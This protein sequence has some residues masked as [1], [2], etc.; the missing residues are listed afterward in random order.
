M[1][2]NW[3]ARWRDV[4]RFLQPS[5]E[6]QSVDTRTGTWVTGSSPIKH[7]RPNQAGDLVASHSC[8]LAFAAMN[9]LIGFC[10]PRRGGSRPSQGLQL[11]AVGGDTPLQARRRRG[12]NNLRG[13]Q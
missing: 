4:K 8:V 12:Q 10:A 7:S 3:W 1:L 2:A 11:R 13:P 6:S 9:C 5:S